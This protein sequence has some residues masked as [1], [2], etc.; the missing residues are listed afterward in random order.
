LPTVFS[1]SQNYPNP[2][3]PSTV[4]RYGL[5]GASNVK[6]KIYNLLGQEVESLVNETQSAGYHEITWN[7][8]NKASGIYLYS[9]DATPTDGKGNFRSAKKLILIK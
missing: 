5:P 9:I 7:A 4:I 8:S 1:L 3:N 6:I 2:F